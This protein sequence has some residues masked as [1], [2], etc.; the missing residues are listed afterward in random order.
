MVESPVESF[1]GCAVL[2]VAERF[3]SHSKPGFVR[4]LQSL[5]QLL[6]FMVNCS[7]KY[8]YLKCGEQ[9]DEMICFTELD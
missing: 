3:Q 4:Q 6:P 1:G 2:E 5:I 9:L 8:D 7:L